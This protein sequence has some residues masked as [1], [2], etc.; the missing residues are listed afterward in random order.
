MIPTAHVT[1][2]TRALLDH[3]DA[4]DLPFPREIDA[5][6]SFGDY[7]PDSLLI[8]LPHAALNAWLDS[9]LVDTEDN[10][11]RSHPA[12]TSYVRT[13][14]GTR[15]PNTGVRVVVYVLRP[16]PLRGSHLHAVTA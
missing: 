8:N 6:G 3:I 9:L 7:N 1:A 16:V 10:H 14:Y 12:G 4:Y 2:A 13:L 11:E 15:L 5:P